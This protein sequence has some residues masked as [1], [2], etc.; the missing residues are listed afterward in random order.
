MMSKPCHC[1]SGRLFERC[2]GPILDGSRQP[3]TAVAL[4]R[5]RYTAYVLRDEAYLLAS[6]YPETRQ[7]RIDFGEE[8]WTRLVIKDRT[9]GRAWDRLGTVGF[10]AHYEENGETHVLEEVSL[11]IQEDRRWY[12]VERLPG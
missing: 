3:G 12:Y 1:D 4:L 10:A 6:W 7:E 5:S 9:D 11:F 8:R 2:C